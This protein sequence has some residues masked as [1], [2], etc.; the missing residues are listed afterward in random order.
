MIDWNL[1]HYTKP[2]VD[3]KKFLGKY[4]T[5]LRTKVGGEGEVVV[6]M[7]DEVRLLY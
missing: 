2:L 7:S 1:E 3:L 4:R 5:V 6:R